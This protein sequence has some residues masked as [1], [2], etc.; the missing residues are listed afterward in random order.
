MKILYY[1]ILFLF[2]FTVNF[3][4]S[5]VGIGNT[6][7]KS[8]LDITATNATGTTTNVDGI[9]IPRVTRERAQSMTAANI[10]TA[11]MIYINEVVTGST[12]GTT[13]NV[14]AIG[15]YFFNGTTWEK[16]TTGPTTN[17]SLTGNSGTNAGTNYI[18]TNDV[19][20]FVV[21]TS[22]VANTP[23][24]RMRVTTAGA[25]GINNIPTGTTTALLTINPNTNTIRSGID[26]TMTN[27]TSAAT[28]LNITAG[29]DTVNGITVMHNSSSTSAS[30]YGIGSLLSSTNIVSG[31]NGY[32][33]STGK[34]Y[35]LYGVNGNP[36]TY[37]T[38]A[39]TWAAFLQG[40][41]VISS[42]SSP[43]SLV[44]IDLEVRNTTT[45]AAA[46]AT[47][48]LR[49]TNQLPTAGNVLANLN[50][51]DNYVTTP[52]A[53][54][55][56]LRDAAAGSGDMPTAMTFATTSDGSAALAER[57]RIDSSGKV[58]IN[59]TPTSTLDVVAINPTGVTTN[60][61]GLTIPRVDRQR[62]QSMTAAN[63]PTSTLIYVN[64]IVT[65]TATSTTINVTAIGFYY[66]D[67]TV[68]QAIKTNPNTTKT[69]IINVYL[70]F[71]SLANGEAANLGQNG[72]KV[73]SWTPS[74]TIPKGN[75]A[76]LS[77]SV[78]YSPTATTLTN[79]SLVGWV[80]NTNVANASMTIHIMKYS[81]GTTATLYT[82]ASSGSSLGS[83]TITAA[84]TNTTSPVS[85]S[86][87]SASLSA[88][89]ILIG[90]MVINTTGGDYEFGGQL[91]FTN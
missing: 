75:L 40:R 6:D 23:V 90:M 57:M 18:G 56:V 46:P 55:Q 74:A 27:A 25:V 26:M 76:S 8:T 11:T 78:F 71:K 13:A 65:G 83:Q 86:V 72:F 30:L 36:G 62:A 61:D 7:P 14:T 79:I 54:I 34:S 33:N 52:Q 49:Q 84:T 3:T 37:A 28:G 12:T 66:W 38:N 48:S 15:F 80:S 24:E 17:W 64:S 42:E 67:G 10:A 47:V 9:I 89:D 87:A 45:G 5:Q 16:I 88:G 77:N 60:V 43:T 70:P 69:N 59:T 32:R 35:G 68:W 41:T 82:T 73:T 20:D 63:I 44:D 39:N 58:G 91:Q 85:I 53:R 31:Y 50:F 21:K 51:G 4:F 19:Q 2:L 1:K 22:A 29:A 81:I